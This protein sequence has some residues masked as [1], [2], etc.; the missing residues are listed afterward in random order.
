MRNEVSTTR[1]AVILKNEVKKMILLMSSN[2]VVL[3]SQF[4]LEFVKF[5]LYV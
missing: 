3:E 1:D 5:I 4:F 2:N